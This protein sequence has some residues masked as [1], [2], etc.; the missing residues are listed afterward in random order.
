MFQVLDK[1]KKSS[2][3]S[4]VSNLI[5]FKTLKKPSINITYVDDKRLE[6]E[7]EIKCK[8][9]FE[10]TDLNDDSVKQKLDPYNICDYFN[11]SWSLSVSYFFFKF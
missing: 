8:L 9:T 10:D 2:E 7:I 5:R 4:S 1:E 3:I 11:I 6:I